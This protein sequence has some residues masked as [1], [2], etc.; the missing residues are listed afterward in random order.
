MII[1]LSGFVYELHLVRNFI[2]LD[3]S[4]YESDLIIDE[5]DHIG[6][7]YEFCERFEII[8]EELLPDDKGFSWFC[9]IQKSDSNDKYKIWL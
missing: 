3:G 8:I 2:Y 1:D 5:F 7:V 9:F 4:K 6:D